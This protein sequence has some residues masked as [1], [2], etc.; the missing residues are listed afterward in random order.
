M[1]KKAIK[2][3]NSPRRDSKFYG[4]IQP[5]APP[6]RKPQCGVTGSDGVFRK[7][8]VLDGFV[9]GQPDCPLHGLKKTKW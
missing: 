2:F 9:R 1:Y 4:G 7:C 6:D 3:Y 5:D 8:A